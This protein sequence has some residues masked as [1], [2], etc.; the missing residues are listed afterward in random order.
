MTSPLT[1]HLAPHKYAQPYLVQAGWRTLQ[2]GDILTR[3]PV[4]IE[5][6]TPWQLQHCGAMAKDR[7]AHCQTCPHNPDA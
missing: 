2:R 6:R 5:I 3:E 1:C 4:M 7:V